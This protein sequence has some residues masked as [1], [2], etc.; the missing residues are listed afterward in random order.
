M[1]VRDVGLA[2][3]LWA[4]LPP[5]LTA[6]TTPAP[7]TIRVVPANSPDSSA[8]HDLSKA[9]A[10]ARDGGVIELDPGVYDLTPEAYVEN[11]CGNCEAESTQ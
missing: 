11:T 9:V 4:A 5:A 10:A 8:Y 6:Q 7:D 2:L 1:R 3:V